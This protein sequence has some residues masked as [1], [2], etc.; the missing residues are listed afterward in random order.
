M[1]PGMSAPITP[2]IQVPY[3]GAPT[4]VSIAADQRTDDKLSARSGCR[5][6][7]GQVA[8]SNPLLPVTFLQNGLQPLGMRGR[9]LKTVPLSA[10]VGRQYESA[11]LCE[12][13][14]LVTQFMELKL[15]ITQIEDIDDLLDR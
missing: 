11:Q 2:Y 1:Y 3:S 4:A 15:L 6:C 13:L 7:R 10:F 5:G 8:E 12:W 9:D 14:L